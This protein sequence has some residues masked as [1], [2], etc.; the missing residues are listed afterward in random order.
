MKHLNNYTT[1]KLLDIYQN[2]FELN[3][4][5]AEEEYL[6]EYEGNYSPDTVFPEA[7]TKEAVVT[8]LGNLIA[9]LILER[10]K[11]TTPP[12]RAIPRWWM[13][14]LSRLP[15]MTLDSTKSFSRQLPNCGK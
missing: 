8:G 14:G 3:L 12:S 5:G 13:A 4:E 1:E 6:E 11:F 15:T 9:E 7:P 10:S 2:L